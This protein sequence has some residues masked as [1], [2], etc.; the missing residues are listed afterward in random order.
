MKRVF[1]VVQFGLG[2]IGIE[3]AKTILEK[4]T[5]GNV[6][7]VGA[8]D[9]DPAKVG[10]D[11]GEILGNSSPLGIIVSDKP[12]EALRAT[13]PDVVLHTTSSFLERIYPQLEVCITSGVHI[14]SSAEELFFPYDRHPKLSKELDELATKHNVSVLGTGVNPGFVMDTLALVATGVCTRVRSVRIERV[15]DASKRRLPLQRKIGAGFSV[16]E[17]E[18]KKKT[19]TFGHIGLR[20]SLLFV[21]DGLNWTLE[22]IDELLQ[23]MVASADVQTPYISVQKG[24]VTGIHHSITG[25]SNGT[26]KLSLDLKMYVGATDPH[27]TVFV[28][29]DPPIELVIRNGV[30]GDSA[31]VAALVNAIPLVV[32]ATP[33][34]KTMKDLAIPR[35][36]SA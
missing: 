25:S 11:L 23:P 3:T 17:F 2:P 22:T 19:G 16:Q 13:Q 33:G 24:Q 30:F 20:E 10:K 15:V 31:T 28:D 29:G 7:L 6:Q 1:K 34:L 21:A 9:I 32:G 35:V 4:S 5:S 26:M 18:E 27:D 8:I 14:V 12:E 36:F